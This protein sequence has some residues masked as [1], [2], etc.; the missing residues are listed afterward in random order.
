MANSLQPLPEQLQA[1]TKA[2]TT[3]PIKS[4]VPAARRTAPAP[5]STRQFK[6]FGLLDAGKQSKA[7]TATAVAINVLVVALV[8]ALSVTAKK[9]LDARREVTML[10]MPVIKP[11]P[12][13]EPKILPQPKLPTPVVKVDPPKIKLPDV[14]PIE[15]PKPAEVKMTQPAPVVTPAAPRKVVAPPAPVVVSLAHPMAA[16]V[17]NNS[18]HPTA[19]ALGS[20]NNPIAPSNRPAV[21]AINLGQ[22]GVP[23]MP[24]SNS[25]G[26]PAATAVSLGSGSPG[27]QQL[28]GNGVR[29]VQG[30]KLGVTGGTGPMNSTG[31]TAGQ[32]NLGQVQQVSLPKPAAASASGTPQNTPKVL[33]KPKPAYTAE[34]TA[35][36]ING[37][38]Q[39]RIRVS[40]TGSVTV[41][42]IT[43]PLGHGLD[44]SAE[45]AAQA[46]R[47]QPAVDANGHPVDW[48]GNVTVTFQSESNG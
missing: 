48:E 43:R 12:P 29:P 10:T 28:A 6:D 46:M 24:A 22:K 45:H 5:V 14:K 33:Y 15:A 21:S 31:H 37:V 35:L 34:A 18:P 26:G 3:I 47:F 17:V 13:P 1:P 30:V 38:V 11:L 44:Q 25:G 39:V 7:S 27:G 32:V 41:L 20:T 2:P 16:S 8:I 40:A 9:T 23:G 36:H 4:A 19:V 42:A